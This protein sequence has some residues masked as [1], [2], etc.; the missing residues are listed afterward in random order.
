M[1]EEEYETRRRLPRRLRSPEEPEAPFSYM[2]RDARIADLPHI[3]AIYNHYVANSTV[4][5]D[6]QPTRLRE[7]RAKFQHLVKLGMPYLVAESPSGGILGY[8]YVAPWR[9]RAA[10]RYTGESS[11][12]LG[13]AATG[14]GLGRVLLA[15]LIE[16]SRAVGIKE[17]IAVIADQGAEA[18]IAL[19]ESFGFREI[20]RMGRVG[21]KFERWLGTILL[22]KSLR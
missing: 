7:L 20:G 6:E 18:S 2:L 22:Q 17:L 11:I 21:Y 12:Y 3:L 5:F 14:K 8:A 19:H 9:E 1:L 10:Y 4:T 13:P 15:E 16:R